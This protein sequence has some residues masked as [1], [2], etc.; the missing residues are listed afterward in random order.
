MAYI[1]LLASAKEELGRADEYL[2]TFEGDTGRYV[3][4]EAFTVAHD[5]DAAQREHI[6]T[7]RLRKEPSDDLRILVGKAVQSMRS[8]LDQMFTVWV[9][10]VVRPSG[11]GLQDDEQA[12]KFPIVFNRDDFHATV[13][14]L[15][16]GSAQNW[17]FIGVRLFWSDFVG[18][19]RRS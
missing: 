7:L 2:R 3:K 5:V 1:N 6:F 14:R 10:R 9:Q 4:N 16:P 11:P 17:T 8:A 15:D 18:D 13:E 12:F 19:A